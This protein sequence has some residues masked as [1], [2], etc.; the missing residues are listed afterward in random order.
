MN[1]FI[2]L[3]T[4]FIFFLIFS[5]PSWSGGSSSFNTD[6]ELVIKADSGNFH[7]FILDPITGKLLKNKR[8][9]SVQNTFL[10]CN[11]D[12]NHN[13]NERFIFDLT[14]NLYG[15][16]FSPQ[17]YEK[18]RYSELNNILK[19]R[20]GINHDNKTISEFGIF[21]DHTRYT[22]DIYND[23]DLNLFDAY[24]LIDHSVSKNTYLSWDF[25]LESGEYPHMKDDD[26]HRFHNRFKFTRYLMGVGKPSKLFKYYAFEE[27]P[28]SLEEETNYMDLAWDLFLAYDKYD[29]RSRPEGDDHNTASSGVNLNLAISEFAQMNMGVETGWRSHEFENIVRSILNFNKNRM[30]INLSHYLTKELKFTI[31]TDLSGYNYLN[32][33][34][35]DY[36][37]FAT[38]LIFYYSHRPFINWEIKFNNSNQSYD[39]SNIFPNTRKNSFSSKWRRNYGENTA[40]T[41]IQEFTIFSVPDNENIAFSEYSEIKTG[42]ILTKLITEDITMD[43]G[44][45]MD[46]QDN[47]NYHENDIEE[48]YFQTGT[49]WTF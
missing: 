14:N 33:A 31:N 26:Y 15:Q 44:L 46:K 49:K 38:D 18:S 11:L 4:I 2:F 8:V 6:G 35:K 19:M 13:I 23:S 39:A 24:Y 32:T 21:A 25:G 20:F 48:V 16:F 40:F 28:Q 17:D 12:Y 3:I 37:E 34:G 43:F 22:M 5:T 1:R 29:M 7:N 27:M 42:F 10:S 45:F 47:Y 30:F 41:F 9:S 36:N